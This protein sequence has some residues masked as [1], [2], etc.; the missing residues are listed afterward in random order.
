MTVAEAIARSLVDL[1]VEVAT[2]VPGHGG[3]QT[4]DAFRSL[5]PGSH[6][7]S[8]HE[9]VAYT[10]A[11]GAA[12]L[13]TRSCCL[14]KT[15]GFIKAMNSVV[16]SLSCGTTAGFVTILFD[17]KTGKHSDNILD[18]V[19]ILAGTRILHKRTTGRRIAQ[20]LADITRASESLELPCC[21][22]IDADEIE[23]EVELGT[24]DIPGLPPS[25]SRDIAQHLVTPIFAEHQHKLLQW[26]LN[27]DPHPGAPEIKSLS[28]SLPP[29]Y[30]KAVEPYL[31]VFEAF[32]EIAYD[33]VS[34]DAGVSTLSAFP[35]YNIVSAATYMGGSLPLA[36]GAYLTGKKRS[37]AFT[38]DFSFI[39]A[40]HLGLIE[41]IERNIPLK[42][43]IYANGKAQTTGGQ[44]LDLAHLDRLL[45]G[46]E[47]HV[48]RM[49]VRDRST[50]RAVLH[51]ANDA[52]DL[53]I[54]VATFNN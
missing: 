13:G 39:A 8:F 46:Y 28:E 18:I 5:S 7:I 34:G 47:S 33:F 9:E 25:Y 50:M 19:P 23:M 14:I 4:F 29:S 1:N 42:V 43:L 52:T 27:D 3:T 36:M 40:G 54:I 15:H 51:E 31:P 10:I 45:K 30:L 17:D 20:D 32:N 12:L 26:K 6:P 53:R 2:H 37:W 38:G 48:W 16:D 41:V 21:L 11:H 49:N 35:P 24:T 22:V 44:S